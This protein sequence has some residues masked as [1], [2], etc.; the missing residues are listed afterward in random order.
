FAAARLQAVHRLDRAVLE[1]HVE[2]CAFADAILARNQQCGILED[3]GESDDCIISLESNSTHA[4]S[5]PPHGTH[6]LFR[7]SDAHAFFGN[8]HHLIVAGGELDVD[9]G[10]SGFDANSDNPPFANIAKI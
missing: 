9:Q 1:H 10:V 2:G 3:D 4:S 8:Q 6:I 7:K 5:G